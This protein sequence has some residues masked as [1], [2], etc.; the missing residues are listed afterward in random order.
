[1]VDLNYCVN[2]ACKT[3]AILLAEMWMDELFIAF[4]VDNH[5]L[6]ILEHTH[7]PDNVQYDLISC[8]NLP[9]TGRLGHKNQLLKGEYNNEKQHLTKNSE[10]KISG[11]PNITLFTLMKVKRNQLKGK[12]VRAEGC[13]LVFPFCALDKQTSWMERDMKKARNLK[14]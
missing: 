12:F 14:V 13:H 3:S 2:R 6:Q 8:M 11:A 4:F 9:Y 10:Y 7:F 1:M 5:I